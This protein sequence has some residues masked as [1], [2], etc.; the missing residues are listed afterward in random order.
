MGSTESKPWDGCT[1]SQQ[2]AARTSF[3][4]SLAKQLHIPTTAITDP[5]SP[6]SSILVAKLDKD[7]ADRFGMAPH[8]LVVSHGLAW[9]AGNEMVWRIPEGK[10][11]EG[12]ILQSLA[13]L[14]SMFGVMQEDGPR[15]RP[16][17]TVQTMGFSF[18]TQNPHDSGD[19]G[20]FLAPE[21][22]LRGI[23]PLSGD[24]DGRVDESGPLYSPDSFLPQ[25]F[26]AISCLH[27]EEYRDA[28]AIPLKIY[29]D[30][31][32][33]VTA[34]LRVPLATY[35]DRPSHRDSDM[36]LARLTEAKANTPCRHSATGVT[37]QLSF[38]N[39]GRTLDI[40]M[41][42]RCLA[43]LLIPLNTAFSIETPHP[44]SAIL[45]TSETQQDT[46]V[47]VAHEDDGTPV[48]PASARFEIVDLRLGQVVQDPDDPED[49]G[50]VAAI[51]MDSMPEDMLRDFALAQPPVL[52]N[53]FGVLR[54]ITVKL[55]APAAMLANMLDDVRGFIDQHPPGTFVE[56]EWPQHFPGTRVPTGGGILP[57]PEGPS[58]SGPFRVRLIQADIAVFEG[59]AVFA[60]D[61]S[62]VP[63]TFGSDSD[64][65]APADQA[66]ADQA[67]G[68][69]AP[70]QAP[71]D[72]PAND[73]PADDAPAPL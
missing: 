10:E 32:A 40:A 61:G 62:T 59:D 6:N 66:P 26:V 17:E 13:Q 4:A 73:A 34:P 46:L 16:H 55:Y 56:M 18:S 43:N 41:S 24:N 50:E 20:A 57:H 5:I 65:D 37:V 27:P 2:T 64:P 22:V 51:E 71:A 19:Q 72:A 31:V 44:E 29:A 3:R 11:E 68:D 53:E 33:A 7:A 8:T 69:Q 35:A 12:N 42:G 47:C 28:G 15:F 23:A 52:F 9:V 49:E 48:T 14:A 1:P 38:R 25:Q 36:Y 30:I 45:V 54:S 58:G 21:P 67:P 60:E 39:D 70:D 63:F